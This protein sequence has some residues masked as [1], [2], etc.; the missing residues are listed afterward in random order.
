MKNQH[1][2]KKMPIRIV[3]P[4]T[5]GTGISGPQ[6]P[7]ARGPQV[8]GRGEGEGTVLPP[9]TRITSDRRPDHFGGMR[10]R[11][12]RGVPAHGQVPG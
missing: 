10:W 5:T 8:P 9:H 4:D 6:R 12:E 1:Q 7:L 3:H 11:R 2:Q